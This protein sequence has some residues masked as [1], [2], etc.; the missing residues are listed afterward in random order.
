MNQFSLFNFSLNTLKKFAPPT[1]KPRPIAGA[2]VLLT[3][4]NQINTS[5]P[6]GHPS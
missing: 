1:K 4:E 2:F 3:I 5:R 6:P